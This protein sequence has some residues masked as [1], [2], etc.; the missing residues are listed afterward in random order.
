MLRGFVR[1]CVWTLA[2]LPVLASAVSAPM[3][4]TS[5]NGE[6]T[7]RV[8]APNAASV[9][10]I[11]EFNNWK[12][13]GA[14]RLTREGDSGIWSLTVKRSR[15]RGAY[16]FLINNEWRRRDPYARAV[17]PDG[18][19]SLFFDA[20]DFRWGDDRAP[21]HTLD[22]LVI[23]EMHIGSFFDPKPGDSMPGTFDDAIRR[24][25]HLA[26]LGVTTLC[27]LPVHAYDGTSS[28]GYNP[29]DLFAVEQAYGGPEGLQRFVQA[30]HA[31]GLT[32]HLDIVHNHY[33]PMGLDLLQFDGTGKADTGGIY[34]YEGAGIDLTPWGPR[35]RFDDPMV[36]RFIRDNVMMWLEEYRVDGF[37]WDST[38]NIRAYNNGSDPIPA[39]A[40]MLTDINNEIKERFPGRWSIAE[41]SLGIGNF[42]GSWDYDFHNQVMPVLTAADDDRNINILAAM[43][44][45]AGGMP[46]VIY[47]DNHDEAGRLNKMRRIASDA[48]PSNPGGEKARVISGLGAVLTF[49]AP[50]IPL[51]FMGNEF[52][53]YGD[54]HDTTAL[55]WGKVTRHAG[56]VALHRDLIRLR[57]NLD[58]VSAGLR[59]HGIRVVLA[60]NENKQLVYQ[61]TSDD[62][63]A[64]AV[65]VAINLSGQPA[66]MLIPF[67][68]GGPWLLRLNTD[69]TR[70]GGTAREE[71]A[72]PFNFGQAAGKAKTKMAPYSAR[73]FTLAQPPAAVAGAA[74]RPA[75]TAP[76]PPA[77]KSFFSLYASINLSGNFNE[78]AK[79]SMPLRLVGEQQWEGRFV[80]R[81]VENPSFKIS[82]NDDGVIFWGGFD[83]EVSPVALPFRETAKRLGTPFV[84]SG[85]WAGEFMIRFNED[86]RELAIERIGDI[87]P[88]PEPAPESP[89]RTWTNVR[90]QTLEAR[91]VSVDGKSVTLEGRDGKS[92]ALPRQGL[93]E[94]DQKF[95]RASG[96]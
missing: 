70:Y 93:S 22:E 76:A 78:W 33:G 89:F 47:I 1:W 62:Q 8:W 43:I 21:R 37:R 72:R 23:Y 54:W 66:G 26:D 52:Q 53:E 24:L 50:G 86:S 28:W 55:D 29:S 31:R 80:L 73:I 48:D 83:R 3:G 32:V 63:S 91:L 74:A 38:I 30:A 10:V 81:G 58:G 2:A 42:H 12:P 79:T 36:R 5:A 18:K 6:T 56:M 60:D 87:P 41:D 96:E 27:L 40:Q 19:A 77:E 11:G 85:T 94:A 34:F 9:A 44:T 39:G 90:G 65:I 82:A 61:R 20:D 59:G 64:D 16:Q 92:V 45:R 14:D 13:S 17:T 57:R 49:T 46:R 95:L 51:L 71:N 75:E 25:N 4:V 35:P 7:F 67:P 15:P 84:A 69:W 88:E 68:S